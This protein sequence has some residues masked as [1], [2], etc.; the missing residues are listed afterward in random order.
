MDHQQEMTELRKKIDELDERIVRLLNERASIALIVGNAKLQRGIP[1]RVPERELQVLENVVRVNKGPL[2]D[3]AIR[4][5]YA[6]LVQECR[7]LE[8]DS[9]HH[10]ENNDPKQG[11][12]SE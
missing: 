10:T 12:S 1:A 6:L 11:E 9:I 5:L 7:Q 3:E 2:S 4:R 8:I